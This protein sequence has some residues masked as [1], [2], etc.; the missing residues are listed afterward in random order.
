MQLS[1]LVAAID[2]ECYNMAEADVKSLEFDSRKVRSGAIFIAIKGEKFDGHNFI[3]DVIAKGAVAIV[4]QKKMPTLLPQIVVNNT[5]VAMAKLAKKFYDDFVDITK[6]GITG[7]NGK[8]TT[9]FLIHSILAKAGKNPG[10]IGTIYYLGKD[11]V[12]ALRTTPESLDVFKLINKFKDNGAKAV[13]MEISSHALSLE[14]VDEIELQ[15]AVFTNLSQDHLDFHRTIGEYKA[16]KMKIFSL[17]ANDGFAIYN[18]DDPTSASIELLNPKR[19]LTYGIEN[20]GDLWAEVLQD[21]IEGVKIKISHGDKIYNLSSGLIGSFNVYNILAAF[22]TGIAMGVEKDTIIAGIEEMHNVKGRMERV[23]DNIFVD[24]AHTP[25]AIEKTLQALKLYT[26]G[27]LFIVFGCGGDRDKDKRPKMGA[28]ASKLADLTILTSDNPRSEPPMN[29]IKDIEQ[30]MHNNNYKIIEDRR[31]AIRYAISLK[32][33]NDILLVAGKG[34]ED[35]Q[36]V[37]NTT[38][39]FDDAEVVRECFKNL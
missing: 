7:T 26:R 11:K 10:L 29:I 34:H 13:V 21:N 9:S 22:A 17:L 25:S 35:Y 23:V 31:E 38:I 30:G 32:K 27:L 36:I 14:R 1:E 2:G 12:K 19:T 15:V 37:G 4:T 6:I 24:Y 5:R 33:E 39:R 18:L 16:A 3:D 28:I 20:H 8:T